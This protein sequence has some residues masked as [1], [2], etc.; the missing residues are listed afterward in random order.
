MIRLFILSLVICI[1]SVYCLQVTPEQIQA[2]YENSN[3]TKQQ[4]NHELM[5]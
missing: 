3:Y 4:C 2:C 5:R 1:I